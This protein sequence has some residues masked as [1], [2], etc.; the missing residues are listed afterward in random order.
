MYK[1]DRANKAPSYEPSN[2]AFFTYWKH[3]QHT[4]KWSNEV[5][6]LVEA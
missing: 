3:F 6:I 2:H 5:F 1:E 4:L